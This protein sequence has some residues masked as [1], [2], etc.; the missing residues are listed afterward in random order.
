M[1]TV[2][3]WPDRK[4]L[5]QSQSQDKPYKSDYTLY[6]GDIDD[7]ITTITSA[8]AVLVSPAGASTSVGGSEVTY[9]GLVVTTMVKK[10][11]LTATGL[12]TLK[13]RAH[14]SETIADGENQY[15]INVIA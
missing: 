5:Q 8:E 9:S 11:L 6:Y 3:A 12:W 13:V 1:T 7:A 14:V 15:V 4:E 10:E 2:Y